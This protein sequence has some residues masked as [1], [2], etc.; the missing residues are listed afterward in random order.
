VEGTT[1]KPRVL[2]VDDA[3][4]NLKILQT[5]LAEEEYQLQTA[6]DGAE[7]WGMLE[8][9]PEGFDAVLLDRMM[10]ELEGIEVLARMKKHPVLNTVPVIFQTAKGSESEVLEGLQAGAYYYLTKPFTQDGLCS[11]V[12]TAVNQRAHYVALRDEIKKGARGL[13]LLDSGLF[14]FKSLEEAKDLGS[15][16]A[17]AC[18]DPDK[19]IL[20][21]SE[22]LINAVEHGN[23][24]I[25]YKEK[26]AL[27]AS[28]NWTQEIDRRQKD[29]K[30]RDR[31]VRVQ[32]DRG[33]KEIR[34]FIEDEGE[35]FDWQNYMSFSPERA[36]D[37]NGRGIAM[38]NEMCFDSLKYHG[39]GNRVE[40][41]INLDASV[42]H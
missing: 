12:R 35:G 27:L 36:F 22:L 18:P 42:A 41:S 20:G 6:R 9:N 11:I 23:L 28:G 40:V 21:L 26:S 16:L 10:P 17:N 3:Q 2:L 33:P 25:S 14:K 32:F 7:A 38:A 5:Y 1:P 37:S 30:Y 15:I 8:T 4:F 29:P 24:S 34:I 19:I 31:Y 39:N 13:K